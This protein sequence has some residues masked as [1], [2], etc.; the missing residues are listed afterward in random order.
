MPKPLADL[1]E[2]A[3]NRPDESGPLSPESIN[4]RFVNATA[5]ITDMFFREA[6]KE[7]PWFKEFREQRIAAMMKE[8]KISR[9]K[10]EAIIA[11]ERKAWSKHYDSPL[12]KAERRI[13]E[14]ED[15]LQLI[16]EVVNDPNYLD[17]FP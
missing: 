13:K 5:K 16:K 10:A 17:R 7:S 12:G 15:H 1:T 8:K 11:A 14:L 2:E 9:K 3:V 4:N 6:I